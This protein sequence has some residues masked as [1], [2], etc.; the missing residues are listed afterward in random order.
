KDDANLTATGAVLGTPAYMAPEQARGE[1]V[2]HRTDLFSLG[3]TLYRMATGRSPFRG[4]SAMAVLLALTTQ[5]P[6][7]VR[8]LAPHLPPAMADLI[9]RLMSKD[10][11]GR[12]QSAAEVSAAVRRIVTGLQAERTATPSGGPV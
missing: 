4:P 1:K 3:V 2:D 10:P 5:E 11:S 6:V 9:S 12:P 7:P 8:E